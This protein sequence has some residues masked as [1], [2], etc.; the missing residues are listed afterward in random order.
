MTTVTADSLRW[1]DSHACGPDDLLLFFGP[2]GESAGAQETR[3]RR[4]KR[5]CSGCPAITA[6]LRHALDANIKSGV[7]GGMGEDERRRY[8]AAE[9][10]RRRRRAAI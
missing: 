10:S 9:R 4:A 5:V 8:R 2:D 7:W 6:C 1:Q 3:E